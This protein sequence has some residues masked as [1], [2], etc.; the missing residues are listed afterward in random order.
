[1][2]SPLGSRFYSASKSPTEPSLSFRVDHHPRAYRG[3]AY[4]YPVWSR[5][6][7]GISLGVNLNRDKVCNFGC[8]YC[9]VD[10]FE[11]GH[12]SEVDSAEVL[13]EIDRIIQHQTSGSLDQLPGFDWLAEKH[14]QGQGEALPPLEIL[15]ISFS[16]DGEPTTVAQFPELVDGVLQRLDKA[17]LKTPVIVFTNAT[18][19]DRPG[20]L[21]ALKKVQSHKGE[22]WAKLDAGT[23]V[24]LKR[25]NRTPMLMT[26]I[27]RNLTALA[28]PGPL[29]IQTML[30]RDAEGPTPLDEVRAIG[31][32]LSD[33]ND[34]GGHVSQV[35]V[36][37]VVRPTP[38]LALQALSAEELQERAEL[39][40][41]HQPYPVKVY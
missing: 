23:N 30:C 25:Y 26:R 38:D 17:Q 4:V 21:E 18:R 9:Q 34:A 39:L 16:G 24:G 28:C 2:T 10:R 36:Y 22:I 32:R 7:G 8:T 12:E 37:T 29:T 31:A 1:V 6:R 15:D 19:V 14:R 20:V 13:A 35:Q 41:S 27:L 3:F 5:R 33:I 11:P 40:T